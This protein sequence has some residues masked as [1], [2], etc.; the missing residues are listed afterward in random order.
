LDRTDELLNF[1]AQRWTLQDGAQT[2][3]VEN[4]WT[5]T[6]QCQER[7][8]LNGEVIMEGATLRI[9]KG[10]TEIVRVAWPGAAGALIV[11]WKSGLLSIKARARIADQV[12][13]WS[14][15]QVAQWEGYLRDWPD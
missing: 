11:E 3:I 15:Y 14:D 2:L 5:W 1:K 10:W 12:L 13:P 6:G 9:L 4:A 7:V 8:R